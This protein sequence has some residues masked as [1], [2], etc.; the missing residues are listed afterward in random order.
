MTENVSVSADYDDYRINFYN[1]QVE[2]LVQALRDLA[3]Q[4]EREGEPRQKPGVTGTPRHLAAAEAVNHA[5][6]WGIANAGAY[7]LIEAA[8]HAD[9]AEQNR[10]E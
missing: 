4:V 2:R 9:D 5:L 6:T 7:R 1:R 10:D 8:Y 3:D